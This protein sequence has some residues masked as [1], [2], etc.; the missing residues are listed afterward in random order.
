MNA[1]AKAYQAIG[2][3]R[4]VALVDEIVDYITALVRGTREVPLAEFFRGPGHTV[5][6]DDEILT[7][8]LLPRSEPGA[9]ATFL[10][11]SRVRMDLSTA[12]LAVLLVSDGGVCTKARVAAGS[13]GPVPM[14]LTETEAILEGSRLDPATRA[15]ARAQALED[16][17][18]ITDVRST[19]EYRRHMIGVFLERAVARLSAPQ[20]PEYPS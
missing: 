5:R 10:R 16:V 15:R 13:V 18:P 12:S 7:A 8:I 11:R 4:S 6:E 2:L 1:S 14:R 19:A 3:V 9:R 17:L 20:G